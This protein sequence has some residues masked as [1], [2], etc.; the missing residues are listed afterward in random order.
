MANINDDSKQ[1][2]PWR[3]GLRTLL[4][5]G[6]QVTDVSPLARLTSLR[7]LNVACLTVDLTP[8]KRLDNV[9]IILGGRCKVVVPEELES[10]LDSSRWK[11]R[12]WST[13]PNRSAGS[14]AASP[15][16][17][18]SQVSTNSCNTKSLAG[19]WRSRPRP[20]K[21]LGNGLLSWQPR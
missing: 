6:T 21:P 3:F 8:L 19:C 17:S 4:L 18:R 16:G 7:D 15:S 11:F 12:R 14:A 5:G 20:A 13:G 10:Q 1:L 9:T 2:R